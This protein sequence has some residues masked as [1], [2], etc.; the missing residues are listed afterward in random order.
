MKNILKKRMLAPLTVLILVLTSDLYAQKG[1]EQLPKD[2]DRYVQ[3]VLET[4]EVPGMSIAIVKDGKP[5]LTKGYGIKKMGHQD[6]VNE[7]TLFPIA[8]NSKA[9]TATALAL[10]VEEGKIA[11]DA[12]V[13]NYIPTFKMGDPYI[14][15][16]LT[17]KD[18]LV[19]RSGIGAYAG[20]LLQFPPSNYTR[21]EIV[22]KI[23]YLPL[24]NSFRNSYA[25]DNIFYLLAG[26]VIEK[27]SGLSW[28]DFVK[29]RILDKVGMASSITRASLFK[30]KNNTS[31][32]HARF[33][34]IVKEVTNFSEAGIGDITNPAGGIASNSVDM[35][36]W[37]ITQLDSGRLENRSRLFKP[38]T[39]TMLWRGV[40]PMP[41]VNLA[42][43]IKPA[44]ME[45]QLY[46]LG[47]YTY[48][49]RSERAV[50]HGGKLDGFVS[51][52]FMIPGRKLGITI[53]TNQEEGGAISAIINHVVD[54][55]IKAPTFDWVAGYKKMQETQLLNVKKADQST[56]T[57]R[58]ANSKPSLP[59]VAYANNYKD[60]WYGNISIKEDADRLLINFTHSK[61]MEGVLEHW[62][63][64][65]FVVRWKNRELKADAFITFSLNPD[66]SIEQAKMKAISPVTD[67]SYDFHNLLLK[68][69]KSDKK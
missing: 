54:H 56:S 45:Y 18:L 5:L 63:Y 58:N 31:A 17:I 25:Y 36:R 37:M 34:G 1:N 30:T 9:F 59:L 39:A 7:Q 6:R 61:G 48:N 28:E 19:H 15:S 8:S 49:Y 44:Q 42:A 47:F 12:P 3:R 41:V 51:R 52:V 27:V 65:T 13:I 62:Q 23:Q 53:L 26:E 46:A 57:A 64:D 14:T 38:S 35:S 2:F 67:P 33:D 55:F 40:T 4:F 66:G 69:L 68:P 24:V 16:Q 32:S 29:Q 21:A 20:D 10:L 22:S 50:V 60:A 11:W 43:E